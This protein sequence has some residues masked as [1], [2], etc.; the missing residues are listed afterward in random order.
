MEDEDNNENQ[1]INNPNTKENIS[2]NN[3]RYL[4]TY[5][6]IAVLIF[7]FIIRMYY[8]YWCIDVK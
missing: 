1:D 6:I 5:I 8:F 7:A 2:P 4:I 3:K